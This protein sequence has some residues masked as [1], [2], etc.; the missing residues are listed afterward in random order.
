MYTKRQKSLFKHIDFVILDHFV[1]LVS[2]ACSCFLRYGL[3]NYKT[4]YGKYITTLYTKLFFLIL[5]VNAF[6]I[7]L[8]EGYKN[9]VRRGYIKELKIVVIHCAVVDMV[10]LVYLFVIHQTGLYSRIVLTYFLLFQVILTFILRCLNKHRVRCYMCTNPDVEQMLIITDKLHEKQCVEELST[11]LYRNYRIV[12][13]VRT[14]VEKIEQVENKDQSNT[15]NAMEEPAQVYQ[16][17]EQYA[18]TEEISNG[19]IYRMI[20]YSQLE[21]Y[22]LTHVVDSVFINADLEESLKDRM[23]DLLEKSGVTVHLN[24]VRMPH[25]SSNQAVERIGNYIV[26]S[27]GMRITTMREKIIKRS[28]DI[29]GGIAGVVLTGIATIFLAPIIYIQSPGPIF[30]CQKRVGKNGRIFNMYKFRSMYPDAE[31]RKKELMEHNKMDGLMF[32]MEN[33]PRIIPIGRFIRKYSIDELPQFLNVLKGDMSLV[34]T[35]PPTVDEYEQYELHQKGRLNSKPGITGLW[36]VSGRSDIT[37]F[38][39]V[40]RLDKEYIANWSLGSDIRILLKTVWMVVK[41]RGAE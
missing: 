7:V 32:K 2:M 17:E 13:I 11:D 30:F 35:R 21:E 8:M 26:V 9:I 19:T 29:A 41:G 36:Q 1:I 16:Y 34:G 10:V 12:G 40:V 3:L 31:E 28:L 27:S 20:G 37:D 6:L 22:L 5:L 15:M 33:D 39:E 4:D 23:V 25:G 18:A 38:D 24:L 14:D